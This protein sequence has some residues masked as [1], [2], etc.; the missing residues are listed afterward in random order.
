MTYEGIM[1]TIPIEKQLQ[2]INIADG[3]DQ[4][5]LNDISHQVSMG[6]EIDVSSRKGWMEKNEGYMKLAAQI[7]E[8]KSWPWENAASVK[9][10]LLS[11]AS[12]QFAARAHQQLVPNQKVV[13]GKVIGKPS[14]EK[15]AKA[16]RISQHMSYQILEE[17]DNWEDEMDRLCL[18]IA[19]C[20]NAY[21]KTYR[22]PGKNVSELVL[23]QDLVVNYY[24]KS[25]EQASR[26]SHILLYYNN[27]LET[28]Y[29]SGEFLRPEDDLPVPQMMSKDKTG[30]EIKGEKP[31]ERDEDA[32]HR[33][34]EQHCFYDLDGDGYKE[35][36]IIT[37]H[38]ESGIILRIVARYYA[39]DITF[40][41]NEVVKINPE[42]YF[43]NFIFVPSVTSGV[44]GQGFGSLLGSMNETANSIIN[45]LLDA[46]TLSNLPSGFIGRG[47]KGA[48]GRM[49]FAPGEF[50]QLNSSGSDLKNNIVLMPT[51]EPSGTMFSL[52]GMML[53][54]GNQLSSVTDLMSGK[55]PGQNQPYSTTSDLLQQGQM[56]FS[57]IY[58]RQHRSLKKEFKKLFELNKLYVD[59]EEYFEI[60][61][62]TD[63]ERGKISGSDYQEDTDVM[64]ASDPTI[65]TN[66]EKLMKAEALGSF[67]QMG[68]VNAQVGTRRILE[69]QGQE[70]I[71]ELM[72]M[73]EP[74]PNPE[75]MLKEKE[76]A[77][78]EMEVMG[79]LQLTAA[80][81]E[82]QAARDNAA[83]VLTYAKAQAEGDRIK[84]EQFK[85][86]MDTAHKEADR[87]AKEF[88]VQMKALTEKYKADN[89]RESRPSA[90]E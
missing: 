74:Q 14:D 24:A 16:E 66:Q 58:K 43:T 54:A 25:I 80:K 21:K 86:Q 42:E 1:K 73:P 70:G 33:L 88:E 8:T 60:L 49:P 47:V 27:E 55:S 15:R 11:I 32:P 61:D 85:A 5:V 34:I 40:N 71:D 82:A 3:L 31:P 37:F 36:V 89:T 7:K 30:D 76:L 57:S 84:I 90:E 50:K 2:S 79:G 68:T 19:I 83:T 10:P 41:G 48:K 12:L 45:Q 65:S 53:D 77:I 87:T 44:H 18:V 75:L 28:A 35:P 13:K 51:K 67:M 20:G 46:G 62:S 4:D 38:E 69:A 63:E 26:K 64:P 72:T 81:N 39:K 56:V 17:M 23:T 29:R 52:L 22:V 9:Y 78:R 59:E 6:Y